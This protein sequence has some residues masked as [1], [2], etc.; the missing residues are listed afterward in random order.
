MK[1][2]IMV[3]ILIVICV[4]AIVSVPIYEKIYPCRQGHTEIQYQAPVSV[5]VGGS[6]YGGGI[7]IPMGN[8]TPMSVEV[9]DK[10]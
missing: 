7:G 9:C 5:V 1:T 8:M 6:K 2:I 10:R 4:G 3:T